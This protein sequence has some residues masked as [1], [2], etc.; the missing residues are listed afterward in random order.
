MGLAPDSLVWF[1]KKRRASELIA[2]AEETMFAKLEDSH[3]LA[4]VP[5][6]W[7]QMKLKNL[8][9]KPRRQRSLRS[10]P[11]SSRKY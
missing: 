7:R 4:D 1:N 5:R 6:S 3:F 8:M 11:F 9:R 10:S 2:E